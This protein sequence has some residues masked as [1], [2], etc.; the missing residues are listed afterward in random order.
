M[1]SR[2][3]AGGVLVLSCLVLG[4]L[5]FGRPFETDLAF[6]LPTSPD[7][8]TATL[9]QRAHKGPQNQLIL[10]E[11]YGG[12]PHA[13]E[14]LAVALGQRLEK[15]TEIRRVSHGPDG[16]LLTALERTLFPYRLL[17]SDLP[18]SEGVWTAKALH[19]ALI[20]RL[21]A[22]EGTAGPLQ[23][24]WLQKDPLGFWPRY[25]E[26]IQGNFA[27][28]TRN[29]FWTEPT[30]QGV[31]ILIDTVAKAYDLDA[32]EALATS[33]RRHFNELCGTC[34]QQITLG[35]PSLLA[36]EANQTISREAAL[37]SGLNTVL[38]CLLMLFIYRDLRILGLSLIP[39]VTGLAFGVAAVKFGYGT[40]HAITLGF[41]GTLLGVAA[42]YPNHVFTHLKANTPLRMSL[43]TVWPTLRLGVLT[44][45]AGFGMMWFSDFRGLRELGLFAAAGL[46]GAGLATRWVMPALTPDSLAPPR[47][48]LWHQAPPRS[49][50]RG[51]LIA[52]PFMITTLSLGLFTTARIPLFN[53]DIQTLNPVPANRLLEDIEL[54]RA[55][56]LPDLRWIIQI[57]GDTLEQALVR[58][59]ALRPQLEQLRSEGVLSQFDLVSDY[60]PSQRS[61]QLRRS[62]LPTAVELT[63]ALDQAVAK[64]PFKRSALEPFLMD[65]RDLG[66][67]KDLTLEDLKDTPLFIKL[68][69]ML[70]VQPDQTLL[71]VPLSG[72]RE[73]DPIQHALSS[74]PQQ[75][76]R[77]RDLGGVV[78]EAIRTSR[79]DAMKHLGLGVLAIALLLW[80]GLKGAT[81]MLRVMLPMLLASVST[82][83]FM[84][85]FFNGLTV[86]HLAS[87]LLVMGL[88]LDQALFFNRESHDARERQQ[89]HS[90]L[91]VCSL[92]SIFAFGGLALSSI[93][94]LQAIGATVATG[95]VLAISFGAALAKPSTDPR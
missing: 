20:E 25:L 52:L 91:I 39:L 88:S 21:S 53:D 47:F 60:L 33:I 30:H 71:F 8:E 5:F 64:T 16:R 86:Y 94:L 49:R 57:K 35:G 34:Q 3:W 12:E 73:I 17:L 66:T 92:S 27:L 2:A 32:Q 41:G 63:Q 54:Q 1:S 31:L 46:L 89:T 7:P 56:G 14:Q 10:A 18:G 24:K 59:E 84:A 28:P 40:I 26:Q 70:S 44:N 45:V 4:S 93:G 42:D 58:A 76:V 22:L 37:L 65:A 68:N 36:V 38:V 80:I 62:Q 15:M 87:L 67:L 77:L 69:L 79:M 48:C 55:F 74:K 81:R 82:A 43:L 19:G 95:A 75:G 29:G 72:I 83:L 11:V 23:E 85:V 90:A 50:P 78:S 6:F 51:A 9:L 13:C 61:Q